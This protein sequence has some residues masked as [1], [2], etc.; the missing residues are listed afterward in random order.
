[1][2]SDVRA[3]IQRS[4]PKTSNFCGGQ[5]V[6]ICSSTLG[7]FYP[8]EYCFIL[9]YRMLFGD[10]ILG[11][12]TESIPTSK[13]TLAEQRQNERI[14]QI[15]ELSPYAC[16][17]GDWSHSIDPYAAVLVEA[18]SREIGRVDWL[19][20]R[21]IMEDADPNTP[22]TS[23]RLDTRCRYTKWTHRA[24][25]EVEYLKDLEGGIISGNVDT[26][27][28]DP[29]VA[30]RFQRLPFGASVSRVR[31]VKL[32]APADDQEA[33]TPSS[34]SP[35]S[36]QPLTDQQFSE[37]TEAESSHS[38]TSNQSTPSSIAALDDNQRWVW[39]DELGKYHVFL[40][41]TVES[42]GGKY[43]SFCLKQTLHNEAAG[44]DS[45]SV[46]E[47]SQEMQFCVKQAQQGARFLQAVGSDGNS[48]RLADAS[49]EQRY[50]Y[51]E[52]DVHFLADGK[53]SLMI[54]DEENFLDSLVQAEAR[55][56]YRPL[57]A[58]DAAWIDGKYDGRL[59]K[60]FITR[61]IFLSPSYLCLL[62]IINL[63][64]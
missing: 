23:W 18:P 1:M 6:F 48:I 56:A 29:D 34:H 19:M 32:D 27:F 52:S 8:R 47:A 12:L 24:V 31:L 55:R 51:S 5:S 22:C 21:L 63:F 54:P 28:S 4:D 11:N 38:A 44:S 60:F 17:L 58:R 57:L 26:W 15:F 53:F 33:A 59:V 50:G 46:H 40:I 39:E 7:T 62:I 30:Q 43:P 14:D 49:Q 42:H 37:L 10:I 3:L 25:C 36:Q 64:F 9:L 61:T 20:E 13:F 45:D 35:T 41:N 2:T 16:I